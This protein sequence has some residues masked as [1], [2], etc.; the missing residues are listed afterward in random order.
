MNSSSNA[1]PPPP[2]PDPKPGEGSDANKP[3]NNHNRRKNRR[4]GGGFGQ[5][6]FKGMTDALKGHVY[7]VSNQDSRNTDSYQKTTRVISEYIASTFEN[8][9]EFRMGLVNLHLDELTEPTL[10]EDEQN[11]RSS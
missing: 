3:K 6:K 10:T 7:D 4:G 11:H 5:P 9:G 2:G 8:A 1:S